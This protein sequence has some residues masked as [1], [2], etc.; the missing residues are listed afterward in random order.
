MLYEVALSCGAQIRLSSQVI[1]I[2]PTEKSVTLSSG[3]II[4]ADVVVGADG[5]DGLSRKILL[6]ES[7]DSS[8]GHGHKLNMYW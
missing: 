1:S 2:N 3:E 6:E 8:F 5:I 7:A 4:T